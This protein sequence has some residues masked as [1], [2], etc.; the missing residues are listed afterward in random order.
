MVHA[1]S[2]QDIEHARH[3]FRIMS[4][5]AYEYARI[6]QLINVCQPRY[7]D[8]KTLHTSNQAMIRGKFF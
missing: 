3:F 7:A 4:T 2:S 1:K 6:A 8:T 5:L